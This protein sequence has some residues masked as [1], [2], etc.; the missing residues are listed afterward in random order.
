M[1]TF[2]YKSL[3]SLSFIFLFFINCAL[4]EK[5]IRAT[6]R[7]GTAT[8]NVTEIAGKEMVRMRSTTIDM[9]L[10]LLK[11]GKF[12]G[13][14]APEHNRLDETLTLETVGLRIKSIEALRSYGGLILALGSDNS[15]SVERAAQNFLENIEE[16]QPNSRKLSN[17]QKTALLK[18]VKLL[19]GWF[20]GYKKR[21]AIKQILKN[22]QAQ[23]DTLCDMLSED[24]DDSK[25][26]IATQYQITSN[27]LIVSAD[28]ALDMTDSLRTKIIALRSIRNA[29]ENRKR[30][31]SLHR[32]ISDA[33]LE[34]KK[35]NNELAE[36]FLND[37]V[38]LSDVKG[39]VSKVR[40]IQEIAQILK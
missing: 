24:F 9:N 22:T 8:E 1:K 30:K 23:V 39:F 26:K 7:F 38:D 25:G 19:S 27:R 6:E 10:E 32:N 21:E 13:N 35:A 18:S 31:D 33:F 4:N 20:T 28:E 16:L 40:T 34:L 37:K 17:N 2:Y 36:A 14:N 5:Q 15:D 29:G 3:F 11:L 12:S